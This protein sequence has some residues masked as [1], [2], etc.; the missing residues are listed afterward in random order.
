MKREVTQ[1]KQIISP[2][3]VD[4]GAFIEDCFARRVLVLKDP[5]LAI[6]I[7]KIIKIM[8]RLIRTILM[9]LILILI[10]IKILVK[11]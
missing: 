7:I 1:C 9:L 10:L 5:S 3:G 2:C 4:K 8:I 11:I 6:M